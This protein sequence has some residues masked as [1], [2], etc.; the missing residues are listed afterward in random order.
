MNSSMLV[1]T[2]ARWTGRIIG[3]LSVA[4]FMFFLIGESME[5]RGHGQFPTLRWDELLLF[6][7]LFFSFGGIAVAWRRERLGAWCIF[8]G[9]A[10]FAGLMLVRGQAFGLV[11]MSP[12]FLI[13]VLFYVSWLLRKRLRSL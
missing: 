13:A 9:A 2:L 8:S 3:L 10:L 7:F 5:G 6:V 11:M 1:P 4:F 12:L